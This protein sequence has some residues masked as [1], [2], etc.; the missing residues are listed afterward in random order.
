MRERG[1]SVDPKLGYQENSGATHY[2]RIKKLADVRRVKRWPRSS[3]SKMN[4]IQAHLPRKTSSVPSPLGIPISAQVVKC[5]LYPMLPGV[6]VW[7]TLKSMWPK[8]QLNSISTFDWHTWETGT[9]FMETPKLVGYNLGAGPGN[10]DIRL[11]MKT[12]PRKSELKDQ[13]SS[14]SD[15][16]HPFNP[17]P[18]VH[19]TSPILGWADQFPVLLNLTW[20]AVN[21]KQEILRNTS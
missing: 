14:S 20:P 15:D 21:Y 17:D 12:T 4:W 18:S 7:S 6:C 8:G 10:L 2:F 16:I 19:E 13:E 11:K 3:L 5:W 1:E 9:I